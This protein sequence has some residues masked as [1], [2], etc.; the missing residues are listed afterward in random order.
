M[1][2]QRCNTIARSGATRS[3]SSTSFAATPSPGVFA[4]R[5]REM[6]R[7][8]SLTPDEMHVLCKRRDWLQ[9]QVQ[10]FRLPSS[11]AMPAA[12]TAASNGSPDAAAAPVY[13]RTPADACAQPP[14]VLMYGSSV[15]GTAFAQADA[16]Y[17]AV[18]PSPQA[19]AGS[20][21]P[22]DTATTPGS[23]ERAMF[24]ASCGF[25]TLNREIHPSVMGALYDHMMALGVAG[26]SQ[27]APSASSSATATGAFLSEG[28]LLAGSGEGSSSS[29][30]SAS[31]SAANSNSNRLRLQRIF[32]ARVPILQCLPPADIT[33]GLL[34][35]A[36]SIPQ[37]ASAVGADAPAAPAAPVV[38]PFA[39]LA[40]STPA[41]QQ[42]SIRSPPKA[43]RSPSYLVESLPSPTLRRG[44][45]AFDLSLSLD[46]CKNS[47]LLRLYMER[48]P[49]LRAVTLALKRWARRH[50]FLN[51]RRGWISPYALTVMVV[52]FM[53]ATGR[54]DGGFLPTTAVNGILAA[55]ASEALAAATSSS[56]SSSGGTAPAITLHHPA[57][58]TALPVEPVLAALDHLLDDMVAFF[59]Y[60]GGAATDAPAAP[61]EPDEGVIDIRPAAE[62]RFATKHDW[63]TSAVA[64]GGLAGLSDTERW[65]RIG[66][67]VLLLRD[68]YEGHS[69]GRSVE[70]FRAESIREAFRQAALQMAPEDVLHAE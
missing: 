38:S 24:G 17:A 47:L 13:V 23:L 35:A 11:V 5:A 14:I 34:V 57:M 48:S 42:L 30:A 46:G 62:G 45:L 8:T 56:S 40:A 64:D 39:G 36:A 27:P 66:H 44:A 58:T 65:H 25:L 63:L 69:L 19:V 53:E 28:E 1:L 37:A 43:A 3:A 16:D 15:A 59:A 32:R 26:D 41:P 70:F 21:A 10:G 31:S 54:L 60:Y 7:R 4:D 67:G 61:F 55:I 50:R 20:P 9:S 2:R 29:S 52:H 51:A 33:A 12:A 22:D 49:R 68:P 6:L 18:F